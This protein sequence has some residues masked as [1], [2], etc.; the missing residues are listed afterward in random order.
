MA[1]KSL[2]VT[3]N[4]FPQVQ[5]DPMTQH[6]L[7]DRSVIIRCMSLDD[8]WQQFKYEWFKV[9]VVQGT[10]GSMYEWHKERMDDR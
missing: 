4:N 2:E 6:V 8:S 3:V 5:I 10:S 7:V 9:R 1:S